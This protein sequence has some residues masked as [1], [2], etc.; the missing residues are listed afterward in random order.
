MGVGVDSEGWWHIVWGWACGGTSY[1]GGRRFR[2]VGHIVWGLGAHRMGVAID[3]EGWW[4]I[5]WGWASILRGG[6]TSYGVG[7]WW[8]IVQ[9]WASISRGGANCMGGGHRI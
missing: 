8:H 1:R 3:F 6:G 2:G 9:G 4:T 7:M 5:V